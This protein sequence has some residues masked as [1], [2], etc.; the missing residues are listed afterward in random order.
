MQV[1]AIVQFEAAAAAGHF[2]RSDA[3][4]ISTQPSKWRVVSPFFAASGAAISFAPAEAPNFVLRHRSFKVLTEPAD[5]TRRDAVGCKDATFVIESSPCVSGAFVIRVVTPGFTDHFMRH[6]DYEV[7]VH[8][9]DGSVKFRRDASWFMTVEESTES[10]IHKAVANERSKTEALLGQVAALGRDL[11]AAQ[12]N[13]FAGQQREANLQAEVAALKTARASERTPRSDEKTSAEWETL[14]HEVRILREELARR[15]AQSTFAPDFPEPPTGLPTADTSMLVSAQKAALL[16]DFALPST[17]DTPPREAVTALSDLCRSIASAPPSALLHTVQ[18]V[19]S[20]LLSMPGLTWVVPLQN[21]MVPAVQPYAHSVDLEQAVLQQEQRW[22]SLQEQLHSEMQ[23]F[24]SLKPGLVKDASCK[25]MVALARQT[26]ETLEAVRIEY[27]RLFNQTAIKPDERNNALAQCKDR[28]ADHARL[29]LQDAHKIE[30]AI[31]V[32]HANYQRVLKQ[33]EEGK[34]SIHV[35][36]ADNARELAEL[37]AQFDMLVQQMQVI[38]S[39]AVQVQRALAESK[40]QEE[41][42]EQAFGMVTSQYRST[43][44]HAQQALLTVQTNERACR[45]AEAAADAIS[46]RLKTIDDKA[47]QLLQKAN[48]SWRSDFM[49]AADTEIKVIRSRI[50]I[51]QPRLDHTLRQIQKAQGDLEDA[52]RRMVESDIDAAEKELQRLA[53]EKLQQEEVIAGWNARVQAVLA[54]RKAVEAEQARFL[55]ASKSLDSLLTQPAAAADD[56][57][58]AQMM[59]SIQDLPRTVLLSL[60]PKLDQMST[61]ISV[62]SLSMNTLQ[63]LLADLMTS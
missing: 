38:M 54:A 11:N 10:A 42:T 52:N 28:L 29:Q 35:N 4:R 56:P 59:A 5:A 43:L 50:E 15:K 49:Q 53:G 1:G 12:H 46:A 22:R 47:T 39:R 27:F 14:Q 8:K 41:T 51:D 3:R 24:A 9:D 61:M 19:T 20:T 57:R 37:R 6:R 26:L 23:T 16:T 2:L 44:D 18:A 58:L 33:H 17:S 55:E 21:A 48:D 36:D 60:K 32:L 30:T 7:F 31:E 62:N 63:T 25:Q 34:A 40:H 45:A 13:L